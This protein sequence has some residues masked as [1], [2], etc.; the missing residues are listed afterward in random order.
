MI[1]GVYRNVCAGEHGV[2]VYQETKGFGNGVL[3]WVAGAW[4]VN[5]T[6]V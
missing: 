4:I 2:W 3:V 6:M 5:I 1:L